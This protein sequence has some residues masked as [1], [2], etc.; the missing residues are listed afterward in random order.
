[1]KINLILLLFFSSLGFT[2]ESYR[3]D[4]LQVKVYTELYVDKNIKID[5]IKIVKIFC[6][7]CSKKQK[8]QI[9]LESFRR[10][11]MEFYYPKYHKQGKHILA[12]YLRISKKDFS[13]LNNN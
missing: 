6:D 4:S 13:E 7:Y 11:E 12:L 3:K 10:T 9:E 1:M 2:Q 8:Q 5:S